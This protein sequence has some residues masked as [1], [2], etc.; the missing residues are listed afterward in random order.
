MKA[1]HIQIL[2]VKHFP[3]YTQESETGYRVLVKINPKGKGAI[4]N[5]IPFFQN[6]K[7]LLTVPSPFSFNYDNYDTSSILFKFFHGDFHFANL[8]LPFTWFQKN[9]IVSESFPARYI[10][11]LPNTQ[12]MMVKISVHI[13]E[14]NQNPFSAPLGQLLVNPTW[15]NKQSQ[16]TPIQTPQQLQISSNSQE[17]SNYSQN[18][19][20]DTTAFQQE[21]IK[22]EE[23]VDSF[24]QYP[25]ATSEFSSQKNQLNETNSSFIQNPISMYYQYQQSNENSYPNLIQTVDS[26]VNSDK[27]ETVVNEIVQQ[28]NQIDILDD[29]EIGLDNLGFAQDSDDESNKQNELNQMQFQL[30]QIAPCINQ[31]TQNNHAFRL[32]I[33]Q[34]I[35]QQSISSPLPDVPPIEYPMPPLQSQQTYQTPQT[36]QQ[37]YPSIPSLQQQYQQAQQQ[38]QLPTQQTQQQYQPQQTQQQS[39]LPTQQIQQQ[40]PQQQQI[41]QP[42]QIPNAQP[43]YQS[44]QPPI[45]PLYQ[46]QIQPNAQIGYQYYP[47]Q[48]LSPIHQIQSANQIQYSLNNQQPLNSFSKQSKETK[49]PFQYPPFPA[50]NP[51]IQQP[52]NIQQN[53][54]YAVPQP[55]VSS[56]QPPAS[57]VYIPTMNADPLNQKQ[58]TRP[59][60]YPVQAA[61][62]P[63]LQQPYRP[64]QPICQPY[65]QQM[66]QILPQQAYI[67]PPT[68]Y[69]QSQY[70]NQMPYNP[71]MIQQPQYLYPQTPLYYDS[72]LNQQ[73][74]PNQETKATKRPRQKQYE[75]TPLPPNMPTKVDI[76]PPLSFD[77]SEKITRNSP[78]FNNTVKYHQKKNSTQL[79]STTPTINYDPTHVSTSMLEPNDEQYDSTPYQMPS[80]GNDGFDKMTP[81]YIPTTTALP[82][83]Y[84]QSS[85]KQ[86]IT[87]EEQGNYYLPQYPSD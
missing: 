1:A 9:S 77:P 35:I 28:Q 55:P 44:Q 38:T 56:V 23:N 34:P 17:Q 50:M 21:E 51:P 22:N 73:S 36:P 4:A 18:N 74:I 41:Y 20:K 57:Y 71:N 10:Q 53:Y 30:P 32:Q 58:I 84:T 66:S 86:L 79:T 82:G 5:L 19:S 37:Q 80:I 26:Q 13:T 65:P 3:K 7:E 16:I 68:Q 2:K 49:Q 59:V 87:D 29:E 52:Q 46:Q 12:T 15:K 31:Q 43:T 76:P 70:V 24:P 81:L 62:Y 11:N 27:Q 60:K 25:T 75:I 8:K 61:P 33:S 72:S 45:Q 64:Q 54:P 85:K 48:N 14:L 69:L 78:K 67:P 63:Q 39:G 83:R 47:P 42:Q 6:Q 40:Y